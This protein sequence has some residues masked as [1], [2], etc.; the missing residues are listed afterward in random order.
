MTTTTTTTFIFV[1]T[2]FILS[3]SPSW[4]Q[5]GGADSLHPHADSGPAG[6][7]AWSC[8]EIKASWEIVPDGLAMSARGR[9]GVGNWAACLWVLA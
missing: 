3:L 1:P 5:A 2:I 9:A 7:S 4:A 8:R 6:P